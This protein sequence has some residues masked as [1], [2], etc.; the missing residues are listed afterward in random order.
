MKV[1]LIYLNNSV[2]LT[3]CWVSWG[4]YQEGQSLASVSPFFQWEHACGEGLCSHL[5]HVLACHLAHSVFSCPSLPKSLGKGFGLK[6]KQI[7]AERHPTVGVWLRWLWRLPREAPFPPRSLPGLMKTTANIC[8]GLWGLQAFLCII[9]HY[10]LP[11]HV[12]RKFWLPLYR[13]KWK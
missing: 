2:P 5:W 12:G 4:Q 11:K 13:W 7:A 9:S 3:C 1:Y 8:S 6:P 10:I